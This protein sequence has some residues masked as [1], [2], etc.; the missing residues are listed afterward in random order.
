MHKPHSA[1]QCDAVQ[2]RLDAGN[3]TFDEM[4]KAM[5]EDIDNKEWLYINYPLFFS[6]RNKAF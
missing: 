5:I 4:Y 2:V 3:K 6:L 1:S